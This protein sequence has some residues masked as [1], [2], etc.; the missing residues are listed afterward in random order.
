MAHPASPPPQPA[1]N[2]SIHL[3]E[4]ARLETF[5]SEYRALAGSLLSQHWALLET[6]TTE[7]LAAASRQDSIPPQSAP[8]AITASIETFLNRLFEHPQ[9]WD[10]IIQEAWVNLLIW[11]VQDLEP[12][13]VASVIQGIAQAPY[14]ELIAQS[15]LSDELAL[16]PLL[17]RLESL[18][19]QDLIEQILQRPDILASFRLG[20]LWDE[21]TATLLLPPLTIRPCMALAAGDERGNLGAEE[22]FKPQRPERETPSW[23][24]TPRPASGIVLEHYLTRPSE[25]YRLPW[26]LLAQ[27]KEQ[28][29]LPMAQLQCLLIGHVMGQPQPM[30][31]SITLTHREIRTQLDWEPPPAHSAPP[32]AA[33]PPDLDSLL[34]Q[35]S[36]LTITSIWMSE[37]SS[38]QVETLYTSGHPWNILSAS[39]GPFDWITGSIAQPDERFITLRPGLW[40]HHLLQQGGSSAQRAW[41]SFGHCALQLL[42]CDYCRD[43]FLVSLLIALS[44]NAP[45]PH[46]DARASTYTVHNLLDL[47]LPIP[48]LATLEHHPNIAPTL[49]KIWNQ[50]LAALLHLGWS[51]HSPLELSVSERFRPTD[52]YLAPYPEW[53]NINS[54]SH[55]RKPSNWVSQWLAQPL[56]LVPPADLMGNIGSTSIAPERAPSAN[57]PP[58]VR[59]SRSISPVRLRFDRLTGIEIRIARKAKQ[60]TQSQLAEVLH[61]HQSLIAKIEVGQR[62][63][64]EPLERALRQV[65]DL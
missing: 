61:V 12:A 45:Q 4:I 55:S 17:S 36:A 38:T 2:P 34:E 64:T 32:T 20:V 39:Q 48:A 57:P 26:E 65:L 28:S 47:A 59:P 31:S 43:P 11:V 21:S 24:G 7:L 56:R 58:S 8:P 40:L 25:L 1:S 13:I 46:P 52:F 16:V 63:V 53:L 23:V 50:A 9:L 30:S 22:D 10:Q 5:P 44:L 62:T 15:L 60:L 18:I 35:L 33:A 6:L 27:I 37:P 19:S 49:F 42:E 3:L 29:G 14:R 41:K 54:K 51:S